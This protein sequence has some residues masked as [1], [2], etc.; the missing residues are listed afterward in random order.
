M[1]Q[2][3]NVKAIVA[4]NV[5]SVMAR[6]AE[7]LPQIILHA[8]NRGGPTAVK[9]VAEAVISRA[10]PHFVLHPAEIT[11]HEVVTSLASLIIPTLIP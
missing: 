1:N 2:V 4:V 6:L 11:C 9:A 10:S 8:L 3:R 7:L 5:E